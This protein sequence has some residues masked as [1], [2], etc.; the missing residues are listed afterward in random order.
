MRYRGVGAVY[1]RVRHLANRRHVRRREVGNLSWY[2]RNL[3]KYRAMQVSRN[4]MNGK[5]AQVG[6]RDGERMLQVT[7]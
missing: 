3:E 5:H 1:T 4:T 2:W 7:K 6:I